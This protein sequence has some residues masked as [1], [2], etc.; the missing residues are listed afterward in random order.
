MKRFCLLASVA[1]LLFLIGCS[2][3]ELINRREEKII[4]SWTFE[5]AYFT[6]RSALFR[7]D[8]SHLHE[9]DLI[10]FN[11]DFTASYDDQGQRLVFDGDWFVVLETFTGPDGVENVYFLDAL[12]YTGGR[13]RADFG[14]YAEIEWLTQNKMTITFIDEDGE[15]RYKL[16][17]I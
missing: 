7:D 15:Y 2:E 14:F 6:G 17:K 8:I 4:G 5:K 10:I 11:S 12:F 3:E 9:N 1:S 13:Q 16:R